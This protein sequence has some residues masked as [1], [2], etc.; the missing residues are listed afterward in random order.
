[1]VAA[2]RTGPGFHILKLEPEMQRPQPRSF[3]HCA[4]F[5]VART[6][7]LHAEKVCGF[8][9]GIRLTNKFFSDSDRRAVGHWGIDGRDDSAEST[10][11]IEWLRVRGY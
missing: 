1:M 3:F 8:A 11:N 10:Q 7:P 5:H 4:N 9:N 6:Y 2:D